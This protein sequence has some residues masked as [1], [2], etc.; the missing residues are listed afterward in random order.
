M[1]GRLTKEL[2]VVPL[3]SQV[4]KGFYPQSGQLALPP[5]AL[6]TPHFYGLVS[7]PGLLPPSPFHPFLVREVVIVINK[8]PPLKDAII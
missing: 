5:T 8:N 1:L 3:P 4:S 6:L 7:L 2:E